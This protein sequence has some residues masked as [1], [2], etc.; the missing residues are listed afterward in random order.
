MQAS[1][2]A[3]K[4]QHGPAQEPQQELGDPAQADGL[5]DD[6]HRHDCGGTV[7]LAADRFAG[8]G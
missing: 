8:C 7:N 4:Q 1:K 6:G 2:A 3:S 5:E